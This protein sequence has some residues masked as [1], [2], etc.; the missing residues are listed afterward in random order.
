MAE[1]WRV[2]EGLNLTKGLRLY[3][4][5]INMDS[6]EVHLHAIENWSMRNGEGLALIKMI[7]SLIDT[8]EVVRMEH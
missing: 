6:M 1:L 3:R 5:E 2:L 7:C 4:V 8:H